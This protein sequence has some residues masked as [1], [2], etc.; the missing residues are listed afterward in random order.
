VT[1]QVKGDKFVALARIAKGEERAKLWRQMAAIFPSYDEYQTK[2]T[3]E[4]PVVVL[5]RVWA[6]QT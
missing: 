1:L 3:R 6:N 5:E 2:T 4:L